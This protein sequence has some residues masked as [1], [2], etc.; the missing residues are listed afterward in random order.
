MNIALQKLSEYFPLDYIFFSLIMLMLF[1][2]TICGLAEIGVR[3][4]CIQM[5]RLQPGRTIHN[6]LLMVLWMLMFVVCSLN[7]TIYELAP[8]RNFFSLFF[9]LQYSV[10]WPC[11]KFLGVLGLF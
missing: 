6:G 7:L 3:C 8:V 11:G 1:G 4:F 9:F 5:Y 10:I 2:A